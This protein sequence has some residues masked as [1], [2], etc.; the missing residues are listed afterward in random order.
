MRALRSL[1]ALFLLT[2][3]C[4]SGDEDATGGAGGSG[5]NGS[6]S[7][8]TP[9]MPGPISGPIAR[10][11]YVIDVDTDAAVSTVTIDVAAPGGDCVDLESALGPAGAVKWNQE[12]ALVA[13]VNAGAYH[14]CGSPVAPGPLAIRT[15]T[16][17]VKK[18][19]FG[20][21]VGLSKKKDMAGGDFTY[22]VSWVGGCDLF[23][24]CDDDPGALASAPLEPAR[25][26]EFHFDLAHGAG[27]T[28]LCPGTMS[29]GPMGTHCDLVGAPTYSAVG[30]A[31]DTKWVRKPFM[32][33]S[34]VEWVF[35]EVPGGNLAGSLDP[36]T[37]KTF[38]DWIV[39]LFGPFPYGNELRF[40][41]GPTAWLGFEHPANIVLLE[42]LDTTATD[43]ADAVTHVTMHEITHQ[44]AG[45]R[46]TLATPLDF[47][48]K[49]ATSEYVPYVFEDEHL[50][51]G[52][53]D[54]SRAYWRAI[55]LLATYFPRPT[56]TPAPAVSKF[57]GDV[58]GPGPM[59][60]YIQLEPLIGRPTV[61]AG[62]K[63]FLAEP[64]VRS[65]DDLRAALEAASG[66]DLKPYFDAWVFG[67]GEPEW[68]TFSIA[69]TA[70]GNEVTVTL[71]QENASGKIYPCVVEVE[72]AGATETA[73][74]TIDF[75]LDPKSTSASAKVTLAEPVVTTKLDPRNRL[76]ARLKAA[77]PLAKPTP[78]RVWIF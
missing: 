35:Y 52:V 44:W 49:E 56:D 27:T 23:G 69:T 64:G 54:A 77:T 59:V 13:E 71:T 58:Y 57:Y 72:V 2:A 31:A 76:I 42:D 66:K 67:A 55:A 34:G 47:V 75:G 9:P 11:D 4:T 8:G 17:L 12:D 3:A 16:T 15:P 61:L 50:P 46:T 24:P 22:A 60:L 37:M 10:Y 5:A 7:T 30:W 43:Y 63:A 39:G 48:W 53:A 32:T 36:A 18:T 74:A 73:L 29:E 26:A 20:L 21:D 68:P 78:K 51:A 62:L 65:V 40:A 33:A 1:A 38:F 41:A 25:L 70:A 14:V 19:F 45:D 28:V 6:S